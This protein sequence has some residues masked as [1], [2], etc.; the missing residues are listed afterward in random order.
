[1]KN[2]LEK[3]RLSGDT[4]KLIACAF[5]LIDHLAYGLINY[6]LSVYHMD[7]VPQTFTKLNNFYE[8]CRGIGRMAFPI[9]AFCVV[10]GFLHTHSKFKYALRL[11]IF[12]LVAEIPFN[13]G[14]YKKLFYGDH[15]N[16]MFTLFLGVLMLC[17]AEYVTSIAGLSNTIKAICY[18]CLTAGFAECAS[19]L[20][21]DHNYKG[22]L[23]ISVLY[24]FRDIKPL[25][26]IA[27]AAASS[28]KATSPIAFLLLYFYDSSRKPRLKYFFYLFYPVHLIIIYLLGLLL[29]Q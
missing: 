9:F 24:L 16:V 12:A 1:M 15:Q 26:L 21:L 22:I 8:I 14:L 25:Q 19:L 11:F 5:M 20:H 13:L 3:I 17:I 27:G 10:E 23:L 28:F 7:I 2:T 18:V 29:F 6:Y 4:L